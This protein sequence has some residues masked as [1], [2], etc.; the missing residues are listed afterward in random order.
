MP[1][2]A[3]AQ[4]KI[5]TTVP[6]LVNYYGELD[7]KPCPDNLKELIYTILSH[8]TTKKN[9]QD[10]FKRMWEHW[11][12]SW[13]A[14]QNA[15]VAEVVEDLS[16]VQFPERK[17]PYI[18][19]VLKKIY[20]ER[21]DYS[22]DFLSDIPTEQALEW[23]YT[24]PGVG[25]KTASLVLLFCFHRPLL[26]VD[27]HVHRVSTRI[28]ILAPQTTPEV[29]HRDLLELIGDDP[30]RLYNFHFAFLRHGQRTCRFNSPRCEICP[31]KQYCDYYASLKSKTKGATA[32]EAP[33]PA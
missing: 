22:I 27:T 3:V 24:L 19:A 4:Q 20:D 23:L 5:E 9:E 21:G 17:A 14:I 28:G 30:H 31:V 29:A 8:R 11:G 33:A 2:T 6:I 18:Q 7:L 25:I 13:A 12:G 16:A 1:L 26:P 10:A 32:P 15:P